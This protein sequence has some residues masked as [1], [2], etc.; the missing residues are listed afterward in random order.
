V[1]V[2]WWRNWSKSGTRSCSGRTENKIFCYRFIPQAQDYI[3]WSRSWHQ[4]QQRRIRKTWSFDA[5]VWSRSESASHVLSLYRQIHHNVWC[6][7]MDVYT[8]YLNLFLWIDQRNNQGGWINDHRI[9]WEDCSFL[10]IFRRRETPMG[11]RATKFLREKEEGG[12]YIWPRV[13]YSLYR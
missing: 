13:S 2:G 4:K 5:R 11:E 3:N 8:S 9:R 10:L 7:R 6:K 1:E 12:L